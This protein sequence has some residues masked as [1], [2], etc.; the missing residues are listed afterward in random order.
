MQI[1]LA[2]TYTAARL[3]V[4]GIG[5][6]F[7][8][9]VAG[10]TA[11]L[12]YSEA[13]VNEAKSLSLG[14]VNAPGS[15]YVTHQALSAPIQAGNLSPSEGIAFQDTGNSLREYVF[16]SHLGKLMSADLD[17][18]G[19]PGASQTVTTDHGALKGVETFTIMGG[20]TGDRAV[21]SNWNNAGLEVY[22]LNANGSMTQMD[23]VA[24]TEKS[25]VGNVSDTAT[26][27]VGG[28]DYLLTLSSLENGITSYEVDRK[29]RAA[30]VDSLGSHD[31]LYVSG[32][33]AVQTMAVEGVTYAVLASTGS[34]SLSVVRVNDQGCLYVTDHVVDDLTTRFDHTEVLDT[35]TM[36]GRSFVAT[37]G[38]DAGI[39][40]FELLPG[41]HLAPFVTQSFETG[42]GLYDVTGLEVAVNGTTASIYVVDAHADRIQ[43]FDLDMSD[44]GGVIHAKGG[45][46]T[47][48]SHADLVLGTGADETLQGWAG[49]DQIY[50]GGGADVL[51]GGAG[52]DVFVFNAASNHCKISDFDLHID[53]IDISDWGQVYT[54]DALTITST[55][56]G[57]VIELIGHD[58]TVEVGHSLKAADFHDSDFIF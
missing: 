16:D 54:K 29:G 10:G 50:A 55:A 12:I 38:T 31:G 17:S 28:R 6:G 56:K 20:A 47:G 26:V 7:A 25:Y 53:L 23:T 2:Y 32:P 3:G 22:H 14:T 42:A 44:L 39:T 46:T 51:Q 34:S 49:D 24:D 52:S 19:R 8:L 4:S 5:R 13:D 36:N 35:F 18:A 33:V 37:A 41:G 43:K 15:G 58:L 57:A 27:T 48:T 9:L 40:V 45:L 1:D 11:T 30:M 21:V